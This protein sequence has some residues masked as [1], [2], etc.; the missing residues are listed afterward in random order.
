MTRLMLRRVNAVEMMFPALTR[1]WAKGRMARIGKQE[2]A[3]DFASSFRI[4]CRLGIRPLQT[5]FCEM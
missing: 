2:R 3:D 4:Q 5:F 1:F